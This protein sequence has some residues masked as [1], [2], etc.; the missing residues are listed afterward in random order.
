MTALPASPSTAL[1]APPEPLLRR[2]P[3]GVWAA[4]AW[5]AGLAFTLLVLVHLPGESPHDFH[6]GWELPPGNQ[7]TLAVATLCSLAG[8]ALLRRRALTGTVL[9]LLGA[10]QTAMV[11]NSMEIQVQNLLGCCV[12][13]WYVA[14]T[15]PRRA[16][17]AAAAT[18]GGVLVGYPV[19][20]LAMGWNIG[21]SGQ[22]AGLLAAAMAVLLGYLAQQGRERAVEHSAHAAEQAVAN[23]R[24]RIAR[25]LHDMVAHTLG[26]VAL[27]SGAARRVITTQPERARDALGAVENASRETL[28]GLRRMLVVLRAVDDPA[29]LVVPLH[30]A[31]GLD[32]LERLAASTSAAGVRV[33][34]RWTGERRAVAAEVELAAYRI[35]QESLTNVVRHAGARSCVVAVGFGAGELTLEIAD[36][37][38]G[39][40]RP[41]RGERGEHHPHGYGLLG[42]RERVDLLGG[43]FAAGPRGEGFV[44][45]ARLP[46]PPG[47]APAAAPGDEHADV[48]AQEA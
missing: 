32:D 41:E 31:P 44:V 47:D 13:L 34:L 17:W 38:G 39:A 24:L 43:V 15:R 4:S 23:E 10:V 33:D 25:E 22:L 16:A 9:L 46:L 29:D 36:P 26:I 30:P 2:V 48:L 45:T 11:H 14:A 6:P 7:V 28:A 35:V 3:I 42:M 20:R 18:T 37:G 40:R 8:S 27:Q 21:V 19:V 5:A 1:P 12:A